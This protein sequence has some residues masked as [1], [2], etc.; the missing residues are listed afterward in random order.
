MR[1]IT[2]IILKIEPRA[3]SLRSVLPVY[4]WCRPVTAWM[5]GRCTQGGILG[6][7]YTL[8]YILGGIPGWY[9][10]HPTRVVCLPSYP[11]GVHLVV[12]T[13]VVYIWWYIPGCVP[14]WVCTTV[15]TTVGM[16]HWVYHGVCNRCTSGCVT[17]V[18]RV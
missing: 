4:P 2:H 6:G 5:Q 11:G 15:C 9:A 3:S 8:V 12:Y 13:R 14:R 10:S 17:G 16:Y 7:R 18:P 1:L